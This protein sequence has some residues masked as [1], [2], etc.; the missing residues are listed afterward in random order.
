MTLPQRVTSRIDASGDCWEW[1]GVVTDNG[2]GRVWYKGN[3]RG[4]HRAVWELLVGPIPKDL[5]ID[6]LCRNRSCVNP[7]HLEPVTILENRQRSPLFLK[8]ACRNGHPFT[9]VNTYNHPGG[10]RACRTCLTAAQR[11][12]QAR[13]LEED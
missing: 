6:H 3:M 11:R 7:D 9:T 2:Y 13:Q 12:Y 5:T 4:A 10:W 8:P 1:T